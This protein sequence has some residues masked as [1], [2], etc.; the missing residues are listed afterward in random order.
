MSFYQGPSEDAAT[1]YDADCV[2]YPVGDAIPAAWAEIEDGL[3]D[4]RE[5]G[6]SNQGHTFMLGEYNGLPA[7]TPEARS[8]LI[9]FL[10]TL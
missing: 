2:G 10:K 4:T 8:D 3:V 5:E 9:M 1:D 7:L 6:V